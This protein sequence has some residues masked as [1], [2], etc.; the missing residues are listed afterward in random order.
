MKIKNYN[1][2]ICAKGGK[3]E[4]EEYEI[5]EGLPGLLKNDHIL[6]G[7]RKWIIKIYLID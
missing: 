2:I 6:T 7:E 4:K 1:D 3:N 5:Y